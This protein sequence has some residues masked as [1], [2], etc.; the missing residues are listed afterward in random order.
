MKLPLAKCRECLVYLVDR[1]GARVTTAELAGVLW[2]D[3]PFDATVRNNTHRV[4]SDLIAAL[5]LVGAADLLVKFPREIALDTAKVDC[6]YYR[7]LSD[8][9]VA[10]RTFSG[11]Y[12]SNYSWSEYT[13]GRLLALLPKP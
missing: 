8:D 1:K 12:M 5:R 10:A 7:A 13:L 9:A 6:D 11:E 3:R 2:E 4:I